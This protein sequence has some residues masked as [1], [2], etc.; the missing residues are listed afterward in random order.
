MDTGREQKECI[1][2]IPS[3]KT[4]FT[5]LFQIARSINV[6]H[7]IVFLISNQ[8]AADNVDIIKKFGFE[9]LY[10]NEKFKKKSVSGS[11]NE[12]IDIAHETT[13]VHK[14]KQHFKKYPL[15]NF[16]FRERE[17]KFVEQYK[18]E[19]FVE[20]SNFKLDVEKLFEDQKIKLIVASGDRVLGYDCCVLSLAK[21]LSIKVII[22]PVAAISGS[23]EL[24][25]TRFQNRQD[26][27]VTNDKRIISRYPKQFFRLNNSCSV[28]FF[29]VLMLEVLD[30][31][32]VLPSNPWVYGES[33]ADKVLVEGEFQRNRSINGK[34]PPEKI[35]IVGDTELDELYL[36]LS[37][38]S[39][40]ELSISKD[41][42]LIVIALPQLYEHG[43]LNLDEQ[44][45]LV[46][47]LCVGAFE[48]G[49]K[50]IVSLHP[51]M[52]LARYEH[53]QDISDVIISKEPLREILVGADIFVATNGSSTWLWATMCGIP[54]V[55]CD[56]SGLNYDFIDTRDLGVTV[57]R[58]EGRYQ[59]EICKLV[60]DELYFSKKMNKQKEG[61]KRL[62]I[63][64]G[65]AS[66]RISN[67]IN[68][69]V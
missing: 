18:Y 23:K 65:K 51:K 47:S 21:A 32:N 8:H 1:L 9:V 19:T 42:R 12:R 35:E 25:K 53:L 68:Q 60:K 20:Y 28:S 31:L 63:F 41:R 34:V 14:Y 44:L 64:D 4:S 62:A 17:R 52:P 30:S 13:L 7:P 43:L 15:I 38:A 69:M 61:A 66:K 56:W 22:P 57:V 46:N 54:T 27:H 37:K 11:I 33:F 29:P 59:E 50:V 40:G 5:K 49:A 24:A 39:K 45:E 36:N 3:H 6:S 67:L 10:I 16:F 58:S 48:S 55:L 26:T 2:F